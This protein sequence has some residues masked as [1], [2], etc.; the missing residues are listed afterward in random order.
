[1][2]FRITLFA[3][4]SIA[5]LSNAQSNWTELNTG[6]SFILTNISFPGNQDSIGYAVG[7][8]STYNG[9]GI[10]LK[11]TD[12]GT[13]W[14]Q[15]NTTTI[16]GLE[17]MYFTSIDTGFIGGWQNYF[18]KTT[19][20]GLTWT[21]STVNSSIWYITN[22]AFYDGQNGIVTA[23]GGVAY[24]TNNGGQTWT[25][26]TGLAVNAQDISYASANVVYIVGGD[27]KIARS[28]NGGLSWT[29]IHT[30]MFQMMFLSVD[31]YNEQ[32]GI[33]G[34]EDG[35][36]LR[37]SNGG[38]TWQT[39][40]VPG[41][42]LLR[43]AYMQDSLNAIIAGTPEGIYITYNGG[44]SWASD[45]MGGFTFAIY[46]AD[47]S[48]NGTGFI[49]GSQGRIWKK[50]APIVADFSASSTFSC[51]PDSFYFTD[52]STG[53]VDIWLWD[54]PGGNPSFH[55]GQTPPGIYYGAPGSYDVQ[56]TI[57]SGS[58][59]D[60]LEFTNYLEI[61]VPH[62][63]QVAGMSGIDIAANN[64][65]TYTTDS[66]AGYTYMWH[67]S[68]MATLGTS[69]SFE[70]WVQFQD[71]GTY[72]LWVET[73]SPNGCK[74]SSA[75]YTIVVTNTISIS[76]IQNTFEIFPNPVVDVLQITWSN[77]HEFEF[78]I[79]NP[80]GQMIKKGMSIGSID[81]SELASGFYVV[82]LTKN[83]EIKRQS[84]IKQ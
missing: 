11:T 33:V 38:Q 83:G 29:T 69:T 75:V 18:A 68:P 73:D 49:C 80:T 64:G 53:P 65:A 77:H 70:T 43:A 61:E 76:E 55:N 45:Y 34:G 82:E 19:N 3:L 44:A 63:F 57:I 24:V 12:A 47:F 8:S 62:T 21:P 71:T 4:L 14:N 36:V 5:K 9:N 48:A 52:Q 58:Q 1:M 37:T 6:F 23:A 54:F 67:I 39:S 42:P 66:I 27:E 84:V 15:I 25:A 51:T 41:N 79:L 32:Y 78:R 16:P 72:Q 56:L 50:A 81:F 60:T 28:T 20:G 7:M 40:Y 46:N 26:A 13:T 30:G 17:A 59:S 31:F 22:I 74:D 2:K 10:I 35:K